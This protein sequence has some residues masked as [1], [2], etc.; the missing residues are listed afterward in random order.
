M[1]VFCTP[2]FKI[3]YEKLTKSKSYRNL[4]KNIIETFL[5]KNISDCMSGTRLNGHAI[6]PFIKKRIEGSGGYRIYLLLIIKNDSLYL[7][8]L[9]PKTG[10]AGY[11]NISDDKKSKLL[12]NTYECI[13]NN[14][15]FKIS[16]CENRI[17]L[18]FTKLEL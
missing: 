9:H 8:F 1:T 16:C 10:S 12:E 18:I 5:D 6:N 2:E 14:K 11:D 7:T 17:T 3:E 4:G 13:Y 15:L